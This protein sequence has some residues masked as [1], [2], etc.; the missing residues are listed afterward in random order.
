MNVFRW[1]WKLYSSDSWFWVVAGLPAGI[2]FIFAEHYWGWRVFGTIMVFCLGTETQRLLTE[3]KKK[4][5][6]EN[7]ELECQRAD[8]AASDHEGSA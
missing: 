4:R 3:W 5:I 1:L 8:L 7:F 2:W 6:R